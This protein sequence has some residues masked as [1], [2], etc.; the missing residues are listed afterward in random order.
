[1]TD[2]HVFLSLRDGFVSAKDL[3][4]TRQIAQPDWIL[5]N[6]LQSDKQKGKELDNGT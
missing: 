2:N 5:K 1:M 4:C 6:W 3:H